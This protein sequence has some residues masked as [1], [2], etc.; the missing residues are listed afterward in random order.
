MS[1]FTAP[2]AERGRAQSGPHSHGAE[3]GMRSL[4]AQD[5]PADLPAGFAA[6]T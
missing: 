4:P 3:F 6:A 2:G 1:E 5:D